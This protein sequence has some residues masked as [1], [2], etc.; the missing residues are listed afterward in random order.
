[1][2]LLRFV[3]AVG[4]LTCIAI[5]GVLVLFFGKDLSQT[6][7]VLLT[8]LSTAIVAEAKSASAYIF[9]GTPGDDPAAPAATPEASP[10]SPTSK[11]LPS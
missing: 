7:V 10:P 1:M 8:L 2:D 5:L 9:D 4:S 6:Q 11:G 3:L